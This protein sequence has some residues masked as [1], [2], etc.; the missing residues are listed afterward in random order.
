MLIAYDKLIMIVDKRYY[1]PVSILCYSASGIMIKDLIFKNM[2]NFGNG[3]IRPSLIETTSP[4][5]KG[6]KSQFIL[7]EVNPVMLKDEMF[8]LSYMP[9]LSERGF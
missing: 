6:Y 8:T 3:L 5:Q 2:K 9:I 4:L 7:G 1:T